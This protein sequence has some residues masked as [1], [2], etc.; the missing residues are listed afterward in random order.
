MQAV[1]VQTLCDPMYNRY[2]IP[3]VEGWLL[4]A[5]RKSNET[6]DQ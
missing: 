5:V 2:Q 3:Q 4:R 1:E 6:T